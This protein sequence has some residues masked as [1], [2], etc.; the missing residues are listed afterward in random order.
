MKIFILLILLFAS[1]SYAD[2]KPLEKT[3]LW[4][5]T[6]IRN[7]TYIYPYEKYAYKDT[8]AGYRNKGNET[9]TNFE[10]SVRK[11]FE[12]SNLVLQNVLKFEF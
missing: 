11:K 4:T 9:V 1:N 7:S 5:F 8:F 3:K 10:F 6:F 2:E 12:N